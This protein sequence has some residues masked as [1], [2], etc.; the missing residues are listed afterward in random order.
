MIKCPNCTG[1]M[2]YTPG[3]KK[4]KCKYCG[5]E[6]NPETIIEKEQA[7]VEV[8]E[9]Q[10]EGKSYQCS[11]CGATLMTFDETAV[12]FCSY[13]GSQAVIES[14][15][16]K[17]NNPDF[18][19]PF[20]L[21]KDDCIKAYKSK[22]SKFKFAPSDMTED[23]VVDKFRGVYIP[24]CIYNLK[25]KPTCTNFGEKYSH[26]SGNYT[27]YDKFTISADVDASYDGV[28]Y[29]LVSKLYDKY[30]HTIPFDYKK[31]IPFN[32]NYLIG[33]YA[34]TKD[35]ND[36]VYD[37]DAI[38]L[39]EKDSTRYLSKIRDFSKYGCSSPKA[40]FTV[41]EKKTAM[42]PLY[43]LSMRNEKS[44]TIN[45]A[46]VNG[47]TGK[48]ACDLP[49]SFKKYLLTSIIVSLIIYLIICWFFILSPV[50]I[51]IFT[52]VAGIIASII[53]CS[54]ISRIQKNQ[55]NIGDKGL[56]YKNKDSKESKSKKNI[57]TF[58]L[59]YKIIIAMIVSLFTL[60]FGGIED[61]IFYGGSIIS[62]I[63][64]ILSFKDLVKEH[65]LLS[66]N[67]IPQLEQRGGDLSA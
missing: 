16:K 39:A 34:D 64:I 12:T 33:F 38:E 32:S 21:S 67:K 5:S 31:V 50:A 9:S 23:T 56:E 37:D 25:S 20:E 26:T 8:A 48:V 3:I 44:N 57:S 54:Q 66:T 24:Y 42:F 60:I 11:Q 10:Y 28:S 13:C 61:M 45:Y 14:K 52:L 59:I 43:F 15:M 27:Y 7:S 22:I 46:I 18:I 36:K 40:S 51:S 19:I 29:D 17:I 49:V 65:N 47:Q 6:F 30:S 41:G 55:E 62:L 53:S 58:N 35:V 63:L 2:E 1:E 4:V